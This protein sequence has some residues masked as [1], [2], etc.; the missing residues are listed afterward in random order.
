M[1]RLGSQNMHMVGLGDNWG[2]ITRA[3]EH[4]AFCRD[5]TS[6]SQLLHVYGI[7]PHLASKDYQKTLTS[8]SESPLATLSL[9]L[10]MSD[11][12]DAEM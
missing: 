9:S 6:T 4:H 5:S 10:S 8:L 11:I 7:F 3:E 12:L 2:S 1:V